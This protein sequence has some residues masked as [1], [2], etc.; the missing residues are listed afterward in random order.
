MRL[1]KP[2]VDAA[3]P[4]DKDVWLWDDELPGFGVRIQPTGRKTYIARYRTHDGTQRKPT[5]ARC[6]DMP[7]DK[8]RELARKTF[9][10][11]AAGGD[12]AAE[13][14]ESRVAPTLGDLRDRYTAEHAKPFKKASSAALDESLWRLHVIPI[15]GETTR[16]RA[17]GEEHILKIKWKLSDKPAVANQCLALVSKA[18]NLAETWKMRPMNSNPCKAVKKYKLHQPENILTLEQVGRLN[19]VLIEMVD[20]D[21][22][23][24]P[25]ALLVRLLLLSGCR[26]R[27]IMHARREW[28]DVDRCLLLLPDTK[29]GQRRIPL[30]PIA[31]E[32]I[33]AE[34]A[35]EWLIPGRAPGQPMQSPYAAWKRVKARAGLKTAMRIHD[36]RHTAGSIGHGQGKLSQKE[37]ALMLGHKQ[38]STTERYIHGDGTRIAGTMADVMAAG[39]A[40]SQP[41]GVTVH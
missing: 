37:I 8:A 34:E 17:V 22:I 2:A 5:V 36:V 13:R 6:C 16:V 25:M 33:A 26:L 41:S 27:E 29:T 12:P 30:A 10:A 39:W 20:E 14:K 3:K 19:Q 40:Q 18:L 24:R 11:V 23:T 7:P 4:S 1:T 28:V 21:A 35:T 9:A 38:L 31:I 15:L 32:L